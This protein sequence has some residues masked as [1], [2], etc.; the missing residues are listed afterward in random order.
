MD[1]LYGS[2]VP[3][4][5]VLITVQRNEGQ[6]H[7]IALT[8]MDV[9]Q[10][11][12]RRKMLEMLSNL[13]TAVSKLVHAQNGHP[14]EKLVA[15]IVDAWMQMMVLEVEYNNNVNS[16]V[17]KMQENCARSAADLMSELEKLH[18]VYTRD[19]TLLFDGQRQEQEEKEVLKE[20]VKVLRAAAPTVA[21]QQAYQQE[22]EECT[23]KLEQEQA[24]RGELQKQ[25]DEEK[26][27]AQAQEQQQQKLHEQ[28]RALELQLADAQTHK[29][30]LQTLVQREQQRAKELMEE[31]EHLGG[32]LAIMRNDMQA[33][34]ESQQDVDVI[35]NRNKELDTEVRQMREQMALLQKNDLQHEAVL[36]SHRDDLIKEIERLQVLNKTQADDLVLVKAR[37]ES[38]KRECENSNVKKIA[39]EDQLLQEVD[40]KAQ[41]Q[42]DL[43]EALR[44]AK[45]H[46]LSF[47]QLKQDYTHLQVFQ[48]KS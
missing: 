3:G 4:S 22:L 21:H 14:L 47:D 40:A 46:Q 27:K 1:L 26:Q 38:L 5:S 42:R 48:P 2:D 17:T 7:D 41:A 28:Q 34:A 20:Q 44:A 11:A 43:V 13:K 19:I 18:K 29:D 24:L 12:D 36:L 37:E 31:K 25:L 35:N 33:L 23:N 39:V 9:R 30:S 16:N 45:T 15:D 32:A 10:V 8:R 6:L